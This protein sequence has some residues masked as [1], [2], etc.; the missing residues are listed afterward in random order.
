MDRNNR[1]MEMIMIIT[2]VIDDGNSSNDADN[3]HDYYTVV[4][5]H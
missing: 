1:Q 2:N 5:K 4:Y 3:N